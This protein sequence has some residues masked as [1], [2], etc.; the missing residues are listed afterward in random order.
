MTTVDKCVDCDY[1]MNICHFIPCSFCN[2]PI[3]KEC[4]YETGGTICGS[5]HSYYNRSMR[6]EEVLYTCQNCFANTTQR[7]ICIYCV[8]IICEDCTNTKI[9]ICHECNYHKTLE[10]IKKINL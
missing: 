9:N 5:C 1:V 7:I 10:D 2:D 4:C 3:C 8:K 6:F